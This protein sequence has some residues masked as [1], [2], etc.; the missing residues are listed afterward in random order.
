MS[1]NFGTVTREL[2]APLRR[3]RCATAGVIAGAIMMAT[4]TAHADRAITRLYEACVGDKWPT[5]NDAETRA[6]ACS[7]ALQTRSLTPAQIADAR[8]TRGIA[9]MSLGD[10]VLAA[11]DYA[12]ALKHYDAIV[13]SQSPDALN[14]ARRAATLAGLGDTERALADY[15][16]AIRRDPKATLALLGRGVLLASRKRAYDRAIEDFD[17][18]LRLD[19]HNVDALVARGSALAQLG[20]TA[21]ALADLNR[22]VSLAPNDAQAHVERGVV[23]ARLGEV[24][25]AIQDF[26][27]ALKLDPR[28]FNALVNRAASY[29]RLGRND[30]AIRDLDR[31]LRLDGFSALAYY[32]RG[33]AHFAL[34]HYDKAIADYSI[35]IAL[36]P[37]M[38]VAYNNRCLTRG[39]LGEDL[40]RALADCDTALK[41][42]PLNLDVRSTRG[43][44]FLRLGDPRLALHEYEAVLERDPNRP[45]A[46]YGRGLARAAIGQTKEGQAD[47]AAALVLDPEIAEAFSKFGLK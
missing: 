23:Q 9:R 21:G 20:R 15:A 13:E 43:F 2:R 28:S 24:N 10:K 7:K 27:E 16:E 18:I 32:N 30:L 19:T 40:V 41:L 44:I 45:L 36:D 35:A 29:S 8:L 22:A 39:I 4:G 11:D 26:D 47:R 31:A 3:A 5:A 34:K 46:L 37:Q 14:L 1:F 17:R 38:G 25:L 42:M 6:L 33:F 12:E